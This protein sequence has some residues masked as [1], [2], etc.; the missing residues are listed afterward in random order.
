MDTPDKVP[1]E[2]D[3]DRVGPQMTADQARAVAG[4]REVPQVPQRDPATAAGEVDRG[5]SGGAGRAS[6]N[7]QNTAAMMH[8]EAALGG[9]DSVQKTTWGV[10]T[11]T[12]PDGRAEFAP[13]GLRKG[14]GPVVARASAGGGIN[15]V[16]WVVGLLAVLV[17]LAYAFGIFGT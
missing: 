4:D 8:P 10:G 6:T 12:E 17:A 1:A 11:G 16:A 13:V 15:P 3:R 2:R 14:E 5:A 7:P 9:A